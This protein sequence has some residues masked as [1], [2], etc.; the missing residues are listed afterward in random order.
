MREVNIGKKKDLSKFLD[1]AADIR[2]LAIKTRLEK[3]RDR[4]EFLNNNNNNNNNNSNNKGLI[5]TLA[6]ANARLP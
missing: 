4:E 5:P 2:D 3:L 6:V 1:K